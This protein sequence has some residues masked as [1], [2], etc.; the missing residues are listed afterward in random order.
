[1]DFKILFLTVLLGYYLHAMKFNYCKSPIQWCSFSLPIYFSRLLSNACISFQHYQRL[2]VPFSLQVPWTSFAFFHQVF[3]R[4]LFSKS[5]ASQD[6]PQNTHSWTWGLAKLF[7]WQFPSVLQYQL[8]RANMDLLL[9]FILYFSSS[10][11]K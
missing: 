4:W 6:I 3:T 10:L 2:S 11:W 5:Y 1:M 7:M 8:H 9:K